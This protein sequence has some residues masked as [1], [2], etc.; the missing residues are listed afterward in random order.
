M[1]RRAVGNP[2]GLAVL[3]GLLEKPMHPY[4][5]ARRF[6]EYGK[7]RDFKYTRS[8]LY[9]VVGQLEKAGFIAEQET[10]RDTARPERTVYA[11]AP[12][13]RLELF[14]WMRELVAEPATEYPLF[15]AALSMFT[16]LQPDEARDLLGQRLAALTELAGEIRRTLAQAKDEG[17]AWWYLIEEDYRLA[18]LEAERSFVERLAE[19]VAGD[20]YRQAWDE[21]FGEKK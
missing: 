10:L 21:F 19:S 6:V 11:I 17:L 14:D 3:A 7:E 18:K 12:T 1:K 5:M 13:G 20:D 2:L 4:E 16:V 9:M 15:G 8:S